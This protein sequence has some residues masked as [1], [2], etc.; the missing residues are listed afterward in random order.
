MELVKGAR[1]VEVLQSL[2]SMRT[3]SVRNCMGSIM[4]AISNQMRG[5]CKPVHHPETDQDI[6]LKVELMQEA[7]M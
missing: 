6:C 3:E 2:L 7:R 4:M 1:A 5:T